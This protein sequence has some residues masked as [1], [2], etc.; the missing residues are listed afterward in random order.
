MFLEIGMLFPDYILYLKTQ[1][2]Q[3]VIKFKN[4]WKH[5]FPTDKLQKKPN[6]K[7]VFALIFQDIDYTV[8]QAPDIL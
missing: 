1:F 7:V 8:C 5:H 4:P 6:L 3:E 2:P